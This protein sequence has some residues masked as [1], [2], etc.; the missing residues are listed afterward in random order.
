VSEKIMSKFKLLSRNEKSFVQTVETHVK[1][2][3]EPV[4]RLLTDVA[5]N[6]HGG[7]NES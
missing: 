2:L 4:I 3:N 1:L 7:K 6:V 5:L